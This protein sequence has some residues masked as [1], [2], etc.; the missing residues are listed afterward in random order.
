M[1]NSVILRD[2]PVSDSRLMLSIGSSFHEALPE[3]SRQRRSFFSGN[4][5][6]L[7]CVPDS[8]VSDCTQVMTVTVVW[9]CST[10]PHQRG[11]LSPG[12]TV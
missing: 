7:L 2:H 4:P 10:F 12:D 11:D 5:F 6:Y 9:M 3:T 8:L 1:Q